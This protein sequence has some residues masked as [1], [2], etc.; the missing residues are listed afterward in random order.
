MRVGLPDR[1]HLKNL[2]AESAAADVVR[3]VAMARLR[4][5]RGVSEYRP[6][7]DRFRAALRLRRLPGPALVLDN[8]PRVT[9]LQAVGGTQVPR[10]EVFVQDER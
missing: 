5:T 3:A 1:A 8:R 7:R 6:R 2:R 10:D 4:G 9:C